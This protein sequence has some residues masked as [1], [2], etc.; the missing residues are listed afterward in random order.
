MS[1]NTELLVEMFKD[2]VA[3]LTSENA[4]LKAERDAALEKLEKAKAKKR[5]SAVAAETDTVDDA[6]QSTKKK[7]STDEPKK[8][9]HC[10]VCHMQLGDANVSHSACRIELAQLKAKKEKKAEK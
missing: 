4:Q 8:T 3:Q 1:N 5:T 6:P 10:S 9:K 7:Q 2:K